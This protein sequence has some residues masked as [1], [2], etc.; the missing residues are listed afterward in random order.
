MEVYLDPPA[1]VAA[2]AEQHAK[3]DEAVAFIGRTVVR[4]GS[5][6][7]R[8]HA[9][10]ETFDHLSRGRIRLFSASE[11]EEIALLLPNRVAITEIA[12]DSTA[13]TIGR[14]EG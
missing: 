14:L 12:F 11:A 5:L 10:A 7:T 8:A 4:G 3:Y 13:L 2:A 6:V 1:I 9:L